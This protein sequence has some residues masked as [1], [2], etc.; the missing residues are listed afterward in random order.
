M[1][2]VIIEGQNLEI[3]DEIAKDDE[4]LRAALQVSWPDAKNATFKRETKDG[5]MTVTVNKRAG[6]KGLGLVDR[7]LAATD[8]PSIAI[9]MSRRL[10][11]LQASGKLDLA[12][13]DKLMPKISE[14]A[15]VGTRDQEA[16]ESAARD[17]AK[18]EALASS[19]IPAGF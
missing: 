3:E 10:T 14:A 8:Q 9:V 5:S 19:V 6:T 13:L 16:G 15:E 2:K 4:T 18:A 1:A 12:R 11:D 17:L 7:L